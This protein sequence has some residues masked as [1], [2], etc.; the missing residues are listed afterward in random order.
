MKNIWSWLLVS[1]A[2]LL[3]TACAK[4]DDFT[5]TITVFDPPA[6]S[7]S[8]PIQ[9]KVK[10]MYD[11]YNVL[12][13]P[14]FELSEYVWDWSGT[15][16]QT[17]GHESGMRY[18]PA[19]EDYVIPVI[20]SV[21]KW[22]FQV[23]PEAFAKQ[24]IPLNILM[25]DTLERKY[26]SGVNIVHRILEGNIATNYTIISYVSERFEAEKGKRLLPESWLSLFVEKMLIRLPAPRGFAEIST[27]GYEKLSF[28]N[29]EDVMVNFA[30]L[31]K[32]R[33]KQTTGTATSAWSRVSPEQ[34]FGDFVAFIV[35]T[36][37]AEKQLAY[38]KNPAI[39]TKVNI[40]KAYFED[41]FGFSLPYRPI[42][43]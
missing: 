26:L 3:L 11:K 36:P 19:K 18:T 40:V 38:A 41:E 29:A 13:K 33:M 6:L 25:A 28:T 37:E 21:E 16:A 4:N 14:H 9:A 8:T 31:K 23:F 5:G 20:D 10:Q 35:Y 1:G 7:T 32:G 34:D 22:V 43:N 30:L 39:L 27:A 24:Y 42:A 15:V 12:F 2:A 17:A